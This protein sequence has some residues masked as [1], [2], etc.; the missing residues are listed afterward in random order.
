MVDGRKC[1]G[2]EQQNEHRRKRGI[3]TVGTRDGKIVNGNGITVNVNGRN[4][5][6][7]EEFTG[8]E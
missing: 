5:R 8:M 6:Q 3:E 1:G 4:E 2:G 7:I